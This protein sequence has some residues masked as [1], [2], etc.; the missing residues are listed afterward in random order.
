MTRRICG[1]CGESLRA[2][3]WTGVCAWGILEETVLWGPQ[4]QP[5][6][7][8]SWML[9]ELGTTCFSM[10]DCYTGS[11]RGLCPFRHRGQQG[12]FAGARYIW[13]LARPTLGIIVSLVGHTHKSS[14]F[15]CLYEILFLHWSTFL[16]LFLFFS[17]IEFI[18]YF[19]PY[20]KNIF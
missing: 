12:D 11:T 5:E 8:K 14:I 6:D 17:L 3:S 2:P 10:W 15:P 9:T 19:G 7:W 4:A 18:Y 13:L 20:T 16:F 1:K